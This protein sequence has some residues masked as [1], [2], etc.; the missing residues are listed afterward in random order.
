MPGRRYSA[1]DAVPSRYGSVGGLTQSVLNCRSYVRSLLAMF[2]SHVN[3][4]RLPGALMP[5]VPTSAPVGTPVKEYVIWPYV[6]LMNAVAPEI[7][8]LSKTTFATAWAHF[9]LTLR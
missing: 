6:P 2:G 1:L 4:T 8:Q 7:C 9:P 5:A 3:T